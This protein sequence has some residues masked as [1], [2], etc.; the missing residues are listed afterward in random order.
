MKDIPRQEL[1]ARLKRKEVIILTGTRVLAIG[2]SSVE[3]QDSRG[4]RK[5]LAA[6]SVVVAVGSVASDSLAAALKR[7]VAEVYVVGDA[8]APGNLGE[9]LRSATEV[10]LMI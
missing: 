6:R 1:L 4:E 10:G 7:A 2:D 5:R 9:A 8:K 3:I